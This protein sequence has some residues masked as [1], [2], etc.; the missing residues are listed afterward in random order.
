MHLLPPKVIRHPTPVIMGTH[1][2][3]SEN[4]SCPVSPLSWGCK[5][6]HRVITTSTLAGET[7]SLNSVLD[8]LSW[9]RLCWA[10]M[11]DPKVN[12]KQPNATLKKLPETCTTAT[13]NAQNLPASVAATDCKSLY[14]LITRTATPNCTELRTQ[15]NARAIKEFLT[16][17]VS[18]RWVHGGAQLADFLTKVMDASF[19]RET[20]KMGKYLLHDEL[21]VLKNR[22]SAR[23]RIRW[24]KSSCEDPT[25]STGCNE[26]CFMCLNIEVL[27][28]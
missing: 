24:L 25:K 13:Y 9:M 22:A 23:N 1:R 20:L 18:L 3:I 7:V 8:H 19:L 5:K 15:L 6:I 17:N 14:D 12:W 21:E 10:W 27:G 2:L 16:E 28:V 26:N 11:L 4:V